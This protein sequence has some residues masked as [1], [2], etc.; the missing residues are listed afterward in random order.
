MVLIRPADY[1]QTDYT[2]PVFFSFRFK[3]G[4]VVDLIWMDFESYSVYG[5]VWYA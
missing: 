5:L 3:I 2:E 1:S 4:S